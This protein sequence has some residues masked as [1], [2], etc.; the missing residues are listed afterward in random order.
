M[1]PRRLFFPFA[2][3]VLSFGCAQAPAGATDAPPVSTSAGY[4]NVEDAS[5]V[6]K[7]V[8][9]DLNGDGLMDAVLVIAPRSNTA[10]PQDARFL[11]RIISLQL[12]QRGGGFR[13]AARN[14][15]VGACE[16]CGGAYGDG[17]TE[18][19]AESG[20]LTITNEGG[21]AQRWSKT[22]VFRWD[23][24][25]DGM[26]LDRYLALGDFRSDGT[27]G[28]VDLK[29]PTVAPTDFASFDPKASGL[30]DPAGE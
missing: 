18:V 9:A 21:I 29:A 10:D 2:A 4:A 26:V 3:S 19:A 15:Q 25:K 24:A 22:Y 7:K 16:V 28:R 30:P 17:L 13:E 8:S 11:P 20:S 23:G 14:H 12:A 5:R 1:A 6:L 27:M